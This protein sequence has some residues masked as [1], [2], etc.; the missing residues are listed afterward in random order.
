M[1]GAGLGRENRDA[2][3]APGSGAGGGRTTHASHN[4]TGQR[5]AAHQE[6]ARRNKAHSPV[7][8]TREATRNR[9]TP[10]VSDTATVLS[11]ARVDAPAK[12]ATHEKEER[13]RSGP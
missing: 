1:Q 9:T 5:Q 10:R 11:N 3:Q 7:Q 12:Q 13:Q 8:P 6:K 2:S 4:I